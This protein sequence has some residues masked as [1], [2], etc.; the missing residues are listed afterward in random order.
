MVKVSAI[1]ILDVTIYAGIALARD[2]KMQPSLSCCV[3]QADPPPWDPP[4][5]ENPPTSHAL[6]HF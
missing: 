5:V 6:N 3:G 4:A 1:F 2:G